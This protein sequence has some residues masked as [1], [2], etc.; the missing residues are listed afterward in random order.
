MTEPRILTPAEIAAI[1][2]RIEE[3]MPLEQ[4]PATI[5]S[6]LH[7]VKVLREMLKDSED[8]RIRM[9]EVLGEQDA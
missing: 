1:E 6:L 9:R 2:E 4:I 3:G 5:D 8:F 7:T